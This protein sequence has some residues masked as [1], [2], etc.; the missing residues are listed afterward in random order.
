M[1][2]QPKSSFTIRPKVDFQFMPKQ[3]MQIHGNVGVYRIGPK[4]QFVLRKRTGK[5]SE[6]GIAGMINRYYES[7][8][9]RVGDIFVYSQKSRVMRGT[10]NLLAVKIEGEK[11][12]ITKEGRFIGEDEFRQQLH[13]IDSTSIGQ[14]MDGALVG[15]WD[16]LTPLQKAKVV[17]K[18]RNYNW[19][20]FWAQFYPRFTLGT[21]KKGQIVKRRRPGSE[22]WETDVQFSM[23]DQ[24]IQMMAEALGEW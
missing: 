13:S 16:S 12:W 17:N 18:F 1:S 22:T 24:I 19:D 7:G 20:D 2:L 8:G 10:G 14:G 23:Y 21:N 9:S 15:K 6:K 11:G 5:L 3:M 4:N